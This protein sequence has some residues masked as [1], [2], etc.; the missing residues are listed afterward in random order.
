MYQIKV[1]LRII[2]QNTL[3]PLSFDLSRFC[4]V[5]IT[6]SSGSGKSY[7]L[8]YIFSSLLKYQKSLNIYCLDFKN[9]GFYS[10]WM[11]AEHMSTGK[12]CIDML[13]LIYNKYIE[14][15]ENNLP[16]IIVCICDEYAAMVTWA[17]N[18]DKKLGKKIMDMTSEMLMMGRCLN[19]NNGGV[20]IWTVLQRPDAAYFGSSRDNYFVKIIM[21]EVTR[22]IRTML[23]IEEDSIPTEHIAKRG[24]G[25]M[26]IDDSVYAFIVPTYNM[27]QM[28]AMLKA[29]RSEAGSMA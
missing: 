10:S 5:M 20:Y 17:I 11:D 4:H 28:D 8:K 15:K 3:A 22:S 25:V 7:A 19:S 18:Y 6:G 16:E 1:G 26:I 29:K 23:E 13:E 12:S 14:I 2:G 21:G 9:S 24:H 27:V